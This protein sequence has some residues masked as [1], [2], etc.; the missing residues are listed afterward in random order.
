MNIC[1]MPGFTAEVS[2]YKSRR[3]FVAGTA[4]FPQS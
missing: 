1:N 4:P 3:F 2:I